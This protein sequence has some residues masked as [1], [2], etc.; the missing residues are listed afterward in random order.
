MG[1]TTWPHG[2]YEVRA[3]SSAWAAHAVRLLTTE[4]VQWGDLDR[5]ARLTRSSINVVVDLN[6]HPT[7]ARG[8][9]WV[10]YASGEG[11]AL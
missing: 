5:P 2:P 6:Y 3:S 9:A 1:L 11:E 4:G 7:H 10:L 8:S